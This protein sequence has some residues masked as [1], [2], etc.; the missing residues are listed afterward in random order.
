MNQR[1][2]IFPYLLLV[3]PPLCWAGNFVL[4]RAMHADIP[5]VAMNFWRW[6]GAGMVLMPMAGRP[7]WDRR[8]ELFAHW[9]YLLSLT[10]SGIVLFHVLTYQALRTTTAVNAALIVATVPVIIPVVSFVLHRLRVGGGQVVG[11]AV[12]L[13]GVGVIVTRAEW[14]VLAEFNFA[15]GDMLMLLAAVLWA[16]YSVMLR[17]RPKGIG[18]SV[19]LLA[20]VAIGVV[21]MVPLYAW[22]IAVMGGFTPNAAN[23]AS[24]AY[25]ALFAGVVAYIAWNRGVAELGAVRAG[26]FLHLMPVFTTLM[27]VLF[28][29]ERLHLFH[30]SGIVLIVAGIYLASARPAKGAG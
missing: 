11:V 8:R 28:L 2:R 30:M 26:P 4:A 14:T 16:Y 21:L 22:E 25:F 18:L 7:L 27:A 6:V 29:D 13:A 15:A 24:L 17:D 3:V 19:L 5:P 10:L 9:R 12:S 20:I 1:S 23:L